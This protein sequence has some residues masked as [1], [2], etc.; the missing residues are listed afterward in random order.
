MPNAK[1]SISDRGYLEMGEVVEA[2][3]ICNRACI[4]V[5]NKKA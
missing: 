4:K 2:G 5:Y 3:K 1:Q